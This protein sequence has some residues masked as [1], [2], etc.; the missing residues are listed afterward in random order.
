[1]GKILSAYKSTKPLV[2][3]IKHYLLLPKQIILCCKTN[4][5]TVIFKINYWKS[6]QNPK[7]SIIC[8]EK[9]KYCSH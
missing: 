5:I 1:M 4:I 8:Y 6:K 3:R 9:A 7:A 2:F